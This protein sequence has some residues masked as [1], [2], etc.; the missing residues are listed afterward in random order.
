MIA[1]AGL[2]PYLVYSIV[3]G[4]L[5]KEVIAGGTLAG[6]VYAVA[7]WLQGLGTFYTTASNSAFITG[8]HLVFVHTFEGAVRRRY[9]LWLASA[10][11]LSIPGLYLLTK[12]ST[13]FNVGDSLVLIASAL[14]A[15][16]ILIIDRFS[17]QDPL[18]FTFFE[19]LPALVFIFPDFL[20]GELKM[21]NSYSLFLLIY[22]GLACTNAAFALQVFGQRFVRPAVA[23]TIYLLEPVSAAIFAYLLISEALTP[24]QTVGA[25]IIVFAMFVAIG[26]KVVS[27]K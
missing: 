15:M 22:L 20:N 11:L 24:I 17:T 7:L 13:G 14:W 27:R 10:L 12:P 5:S 6:I 21:P 16:Q 25:A 18:L 23:S 26:E 19:V 9:N 3:K 8:L 2:L 1:L 4:K